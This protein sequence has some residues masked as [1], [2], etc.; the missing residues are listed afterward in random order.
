MKSLF[1]QATLAPDL[2][3]ILAAGAIMAAPVYYW[4]DSPIWLTV[5]AGGLIYAG[6]LLA[7]GAFRWSE[8]MAILGSLKPRGK[9]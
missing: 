3:R 7:L 5:P 9:K 4:R 8:I 6:A 2:A 1:P